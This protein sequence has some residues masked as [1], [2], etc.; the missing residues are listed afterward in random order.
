MSFKFKLTDSLV[1]VFPEQEPDNLKEK[2]IKLLQ[3]EV[4][5]F[6]LAYTFEYQSGPLYLPDLTYE[7][8]SDEGLDISVERVELVPV[9]LPV[10]LDR[11]DDDYLF[12]DP[13]LAPD[14]LVPK[15]TNIF[16]PYANQWRS[17]WFH[18][19]VPE[20]MAAGKYNIKLN[21]K[22]LD[23]DE[24]IWSDEL[25]IEILDQQLPEQELI[26]TQW[27]HADTVADYY[28]VEVFSERH[29][30]LIDIHMEAAARNGVNLLLTPIFTPPLDTQ[31]G[32]ER[33][34]IQLLEIEKNGNEYNFNFDK[35][36]RWI[37]LALSHGIKYFEMAHLFTQWGAVAC[38]KIIVKVDGQEKKLFGWH[39]KATSTE[40]KEF[41][42][43]LLTA[44]REYLEA[45]GLWEKTYWHVS[46][47]PN[48]SN[49]D[50]YAEAKKIVEPYLPAER[51]MDALSNYEFFEKG[52]VPRP[53][54]TNDAIEPFL[55]NNVENLWTYYC[56]AQVL[57]VSNRIISMPSARNRIIGAQLYLYDIEGF[58]QWGFNFYNAQFSRHLLNPYVNG[59]AMNGFVSGD[60][61]L[62]Y[63]GI[64]G[65]A[66]DSIRGRVFFEALQDMRLLKALEFL[67]S[68][69]EAKEVIKSV[70]GSNVT[71]KEYPKGEAGKAKLLELNKVI[72]EKISNLVT[73]EE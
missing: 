37:D 8:V 58:L 43:Q 13:R 65:E 7:L 59:D 40:Y 31:I 22:S 39:T 54:P 61:Y 10:Y 60:A 62:V 55:E 57:E 44:M 73:G 47:E 5:N 36:D 28:N 14:L 63:P 49:I 67:T 53:I 15:E 23:K 41:L 50:T 48:L 17:L 52:L 20:E 51:T 56:C 69:D 6:Q 33:T 26:H 29:W 9:T 42:Q 11:V 46:D 16:R 32:G 68:K 30:E 34:T 35:L 3:G 21:I 12:T 64:K 71:F 66:L 38:P 27:F 19:V 45:R 1:K 4:F 2:K 25:D 72:K 18:V 24:L 70:L